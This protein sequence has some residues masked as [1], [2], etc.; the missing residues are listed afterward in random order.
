MVIL[1]STVISAIITTILTFVTNKRKD[2]VENIIKERKI[3]R[4]ELRL[5]SNEIATSKKLKELEVAASKL[6]VRINAYGIGRNSI[7]MDSYIWEQ[8]RKLEKNENITNDDFKRTK[9]IFV[10]LISCLLKYDWERAKNEIKGNIHTKI[11][12]ISFAL[13]YIFYSIRWF[14]NCYSNEGEMDQYITFC[15]MYSIFIA[16]SLL[17]NNLIDKWYKKEQLIFFLFIGTVGYLFLFILWN[18]MLPHL[19]FLDLIDWFIFSILLITL[20]YNTECRYVF[21]RNNVAYY[22]LASAVSVGTNKINKRYKIFF[23]D[24]IEEFPSGEKIVFED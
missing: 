23:G 1:S 18:Y 22:I 6:K 7:F 12:I 4:D 13:C 3:W 16:F 21:Y 11:T 17:I 19:G 2:T 10:D 20:I 5:I 24:R 15:I 8:I 14:L 9:V